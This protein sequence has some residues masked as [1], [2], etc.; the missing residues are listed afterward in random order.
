MVLSCLSFVFLLVCLVYSSVTRSLLSTL[1]FALFVIVCSFLTTSSLIVFFVMYEFSLFPVCSLILFLGYQP[2]KLQSTYFLLLYTVI[3]SIPFLF[4]ALSLNGALVE[5][6]V[7]LPPFARTLVCLSFMVKSP[8]YTLHSWLPKAHVEAPLVGSILLA[9]VILKLGRYGL[10]VLAPCLSCFSNLYI[11]FSL[12]GGI[13]CSSLCC[14]SWDMK[15]LVAY[16]SVVHMGVVTLGA[17]SGLELGYWAASGM[18]VGHSLLSPL[19]FL[20]AHDLYLFTGSRSFIY[21]LNLSAPLTFLSFIGLCSGLNF[22]LPPFLNFYVEVS[23]FIVQA[24]LWS[25]S[26]IPLVIVAFLVY[27]YS[28]LFYVLSCGGLSGPYSRPGFCFY[29]F[30]PSISINLLLSLSPSTL[31]L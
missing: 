2:E 22:G 23:L 24:S 6:L 30:L 31:L 3:C 26:V 25:L 14:R 20:L 28:L 5:G 13:V 8:I 12:L 11:Y 7:S 29:L 9:G 16:S 17:L 27:L 4:F 15:S 19:L 21:G 1:V 18:V 10:L